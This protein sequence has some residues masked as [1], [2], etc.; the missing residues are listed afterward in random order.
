MSEEPRRWPDERPEPAERPA[1]DEPDSFPGA[2]DEPGVEPEGPDIEPA[3]PDPVAEARGNHESPYTLFLRGRDL[4]AARHHAQAAIVLERAARQA[5]GKA[6]ILE[7]LGR[8]YYNSGQ[9]DRARETF[10]AMLQID[11]S[12]H[13]A[14]YALGQSLKQLGR[15]REARTHLRLA[16]ALDPSSE[17]YRAALRR[18]GTPPRQGGASREG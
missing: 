6:S 15:T 10:E 4:N 13:Y 18:L 7:A 8:A 12:A 9:H 3:E 2:P 5:P 11:P 1:P 16:V 14:H 17:L